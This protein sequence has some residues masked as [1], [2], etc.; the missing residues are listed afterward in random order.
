[1]LPP[2]DPPPHVTDV[3][4]YNNKLFALLGSL[5]WTLFAAAARLGFAKLGGGGGSA[6]A[7]QEL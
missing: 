2:P 5:F 7:Q 4:P 6:T 1:M 3:I